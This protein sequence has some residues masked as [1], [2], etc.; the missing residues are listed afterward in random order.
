M[1]RTRQIT[2]RA[3]EAT[4]EALVIIL[5]RRRFRIPWKDCS[6]KLARA[7]VEQRREGRLSPGGYGIQWPAL[8]EDLSI[9]GLVEH[10]AAR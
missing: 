5:P 7:T 10:R 4:D 2:A 9:A 8:D 3:I 6:P 1:R